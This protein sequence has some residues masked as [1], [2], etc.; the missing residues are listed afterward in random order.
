[1][2][3][4]TIQAIEQQRKT[5][6]LR[7]LHVLDH[8][9]PVHSGYS[10]RSLH[11]I[12]AQQH[13]GLRPLVLTGPLQAIDDPRASDV[14]LDGV[15]YHRT[16]YSGLL[17]EWAITRRRPILRE[18]MVVR[19]L[20]QRIL[21]LIEQHPVDIIHAHSPV[22]CGL[23]A[24]QAARLTRTAFVYELRAFWEDAGDPRKAKSL[25]YRLS[26]KME[27]YVVHRANAVVGIAQSILKDLEARKADPKKLFHVPNGVDVRKFSPAARDSALAAEL[28]VGKVPVLGFIGSFYHWEGAAWLV[29]A[30][31]ELRRRG[32]ACELLLIGDGEE[33]PAVRAAVHEEQAQDFVHVIGKVPHE[34]VERYYS[35]IDV[36]VYPRHRSRLTEMVTPLKPLEAMAL[37]KAVLGSDVGGIRELIDMEQT[38]LLFRAD[39]VD[40]FCRQAG[41]LLDN[42]ALREELGVRARELV[43]REKD[44]AILAERYFNVYD[45]ALQDVR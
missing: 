15:A 36:L 25:R 19:L 24:L 42:P 27:D 33:M 29:R 7:V 44:W 2:N 39:D 18:M 8:S 38:G 34:Q 40:D 30:I 37:G 32:A 23:A 45:A 26:R 41:R 6:P 11:L 16:P 43:L 5:R 9:W 13:M 4:Q 17:S 21:K 10:F 28:G 20:R 1:M 3:T 14:V 22:L 35:V 31:A 12:A